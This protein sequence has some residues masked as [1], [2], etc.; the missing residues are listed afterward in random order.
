[1]AQDTATPVAAN[2]DPFA[3]PTRSAFP[4]LDDLDGR[5]LLIKP[6]KLERDV[7]GKFGK[8]DRITADVVVLDDPEEGVREIDKMY[9]SQKGI[10]GMLEGCLKPGKKPF[11]LGRLHRSPSGDSWR[12]KA[13]AT[14]GGIDALIAEFF[15]KGGKGEEPQWYWDLGEFTPEEATIARNYLASNDQFGNAAS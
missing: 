1:M 7:P 6:T 4:K 3:A 13:E 14:E 5:L 11:V 10:V 2:D 8:Q 12:A 9:L 15:R